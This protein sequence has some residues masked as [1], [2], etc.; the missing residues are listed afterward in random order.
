[1]GR[2]SHMSAAHGASCNL[3]LPLPRKPCWL[4]DQS[5]VMWLLLC[6]HVLCLALKAAS[7]PFCVAWQDFLR[8]AG[9]PGLRMVAEDIDTFFKVAEDQLV[10]EFEQGSLVRGFN[11][12]LD[13]S[14]Y[15]YGG[16]TKA[17]VAAMR[18]ELTHLTQRREDEFEQA[19]EEVVRERDPGQVSVWIVLC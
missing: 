19:L 8:G 17:M 14:V 18:A 9:V 6:S 5:D 7:A 16:V 11:A 1:M 12:L 4:L 3:D 15:V 2:T 10:E 13:G